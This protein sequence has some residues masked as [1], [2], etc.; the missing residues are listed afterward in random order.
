VIG[1]AKLAADRHVVL[2]RFVA[3]DRD[4]QRH[5]FVAGGRAHVLDPEARI[6]CSS[7]M[8]AKAGRR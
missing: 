1:S 4:L 5:P 6:C 3:V 7:P 2:G 8:M